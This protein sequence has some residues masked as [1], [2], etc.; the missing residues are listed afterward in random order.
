MN[1]HFYLLRTSLKNRIKEMIHKPG[2]LVMYLLV[3]AG[4]LTGLIV[5]L[6][7][8]AQADATMPLYH[9]LPIFFAF[10]LL[11]YGIS[12]QKGLSSGDAIFGMNDVNLLFVSPVNPRATL[13][14]GVIRLVGM[15]FWAGFFIL[16]Q[17]GTLSLFG[18]GFH[19]MLILFAVFILYTVVLTLLS[20]VIYST[21]NGKLARKRLVR[22][23][24]V[25]VFVPILALFAY[26]FGQTGDML[27]ALNAVIQSWLLAATPF[28]GWA[29]A[30]AIALIDG[31]M[32]AGFGWLGLLAL[33][34]AGMLIYIMYSR[35]DYYEDVLV[36]TETAF[37]K[38]RAAAEGDVQTMGSTNAK[39]KVTATGLNGHGAQVFMYKHLRET[40]RQ[41]RF[42][43]FSM[44]VL[45]MAAALLVLSFFMRGK[46]DVIT[47][48]QIL[49][50]MQVFMI[51][52]GRG[53]LETYSHYIY[54]I[55][56]STF[57]KLLWSNMEL[58][59]RTL[60]ESLLLLGFPGFILG[61]HP[62]IILLSIAVYVFFSL[63]LLG[64]NYMFMCWFDANL[65][66]GIL[67]MVYLI[68]VLLII[69]PGLTAALIVGS[70][71]GGFAGTLL[72]LVILSVW[73][74]IAGLA[75]F[76]LSKNVLSN[77]DM[78]S[79]TK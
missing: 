51:G 9:F 22:I 70:S 67:L 75:S 36:A 5:T 46:T 28:V 76:A 29:S 59:L 11:F 54:M 32:L 13:L 52:T 72:G 3:I 37:E 23:F 50:W 30:G 68:A 7:R 63:M 6:S 62:L 19:G 35:S 64:V 47:I 56:G 65:S 17:G 43:F 33:T 77:C 44:Y 71:L 55:P 78:P 48:L 18:I 16:F 4:I 27:L 40:F 25:A 26:R 73:E 53:L 21:T 24:A 79:N 31:N 20:L 14:Y 15:S 69:A 58:M 74:L 8:S 12:I 60:V 61:S 34:G 1:S 41:N 2:K 49:L 38:K 10:L 57:K 45:I 66:K 42:G 39:V